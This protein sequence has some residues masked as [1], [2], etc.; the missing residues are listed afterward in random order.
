MRQ[1]YLCAPYGNV[2]GR[3]ELQLTAGSCLID[4]GGQEGGEGFW[5]RDW[6]WLLLD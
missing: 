3:V 2:N 6:Y 5:K 4:E 1:N